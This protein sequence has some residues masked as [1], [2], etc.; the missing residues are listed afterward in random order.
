VL[1]IDGTGHFAGDDGSLFRV[2][3]ELDPPRAVL[4][5]HGEH[6]SALAIGLVGTAA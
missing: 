2:P 5:A 6:P 1:L 3:L 4:A